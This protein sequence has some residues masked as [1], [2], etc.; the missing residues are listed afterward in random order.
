MMMVNLNPEIFIISSSYFRKCWE[1]PR[2]LLVPFVSCRKAYCPW[3]ATSGS[4]I[5][6]MY[7]ANPSYRHSLTLCSIQVLPKG[8]YY[9]YTASRHQHRQWFP[10]KSAG[11]LGCGCRT[12]V[13]TTCCVAINVFIDDSIDIAVLQWTQSPP[14][15]RWRRPCWR[16][17]PWA[18][19][20]SLN[21]QVPCSV[22]SLSTM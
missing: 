16:V 3:K 9:Q 12:E 22:S 1:S 8:L 6:R 20:L 4:V 2:R 18:W 11:I 14:F 21:S 13:C 15:V 19:T 5:A 7:C 17:S 10:A